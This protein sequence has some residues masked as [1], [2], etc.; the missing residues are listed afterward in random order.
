M[1]RRVHISWM[2]FKMQNH[3]A[4]N[5]IFTRPPGTDLKQKNITKSQDIQRL[6]EDTIIYRYPLMCEI[7]VKNDVTSPPPP[8]EVKDHTPSKHQGDPALDTWECCSISAAGSL[9]EPHH[10]LLVQCVAVCCSIRS[11][12]ESAPSCLLVWEWQGGGCSKSD[13]VPPTCCKTPAIHQDHN[14]SSPT[15]KPK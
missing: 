5:C 3:S 13:P 9:L 1:T 14:T 6:L 10:Y 4:R 15:K 7:Y 12:R 8:W 11:H 2:L